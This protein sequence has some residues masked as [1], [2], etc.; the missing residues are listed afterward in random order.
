MS[1]T[2]ESSSE[3]PQQKQSTTGLALSYFI[4]RLG[5]FALILAGFWLIGFRGLPG[6]VAAAI[7]SIPVSFFALSKMRVRVAEGMSQRKEKQLS[8]RDEFRSTGK[9]AD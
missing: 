6:A 1:D 8:M 2:P 3:V 5:I 4:A 7:V 9:K